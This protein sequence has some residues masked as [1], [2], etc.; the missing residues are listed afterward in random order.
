MRRNATRDDEYIP[1][2]IKSHASLEFA[3]VFPL[4]V[5]GNHYRVLNKEIIKLAVT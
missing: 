2:Q 5:I 1:G 3:V 4:R